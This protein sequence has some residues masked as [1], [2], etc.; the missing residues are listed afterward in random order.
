MTLVYGFAGMRDTGGKITFRPKPIPRLHRLAFPLQI[1][2]RSLRVTLEQD[3]ATYLLERG[4]PLT[5]E[6]NGEEVAL[7]E[8]EAVT[9][10]LEA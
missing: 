9:R 5:I 10:P 8:G 4:E 6:H 1:R 7:V 2:G 3:H